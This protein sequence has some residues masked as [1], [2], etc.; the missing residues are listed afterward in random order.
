MSA[1]P[2]PA[3][4]IAPPRALRQPA[5]RLQARRARRSLVELWLEKCPHPLLTLIAV[6]VL[7]ARQVKHWPLLGQRADPFLAERR[8]STQL[9]Q[10]H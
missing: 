5:R 1:P 6:V 9:H 8:C 10:D 3:C 2:G 7:F 4:A